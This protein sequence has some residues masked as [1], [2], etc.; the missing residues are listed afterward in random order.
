MSCPPVWLCAHALPQV[1]ALAVIAIALLAFFFMRQR[2][3]ARQVPYL[4]PGVADL[5]DND[6]LERPMPYDAGDMSQR[7]DRDGAQYATLPTLSPGRKSSS[8]STTCIADPHHAVGPSGESQQSGRLSKFGSTSSHGHEA[9]AAGFAALPSTSHEQSA[10][11]V[12]SPP[13]SAGLPE[14]QVVH[15]PIALAAGANNADQPQ[16]AASTSKSPRSPRSPP[17]AMPVVRQERDAGRLPTE[18]VIPPE[19]NPAWAPPNSG[20]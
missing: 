11:Q 20:H 4:E 15:V 12:T 10:S 1:G 7:N 18:E 6:K 17:A 9:S 8:D 19:Y 2:R 3:Q 14:E 16:S 13:S 5:G